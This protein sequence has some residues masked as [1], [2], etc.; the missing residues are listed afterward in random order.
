MGIGLSTS[1]L[2]AEISE[3]PPTCNVPR[4]RVDGNMLMIDLRACYAACQSMEPHP[5]HQGAHGYSTR[6]SCPVSYSLQ[7][8]SP[9]HIWHCIRHRQSVW[10][11]SRA[12]LLVSGAITNL[13]ELGCSFGATQNAVAI[14][15]D[16]AVAS[17]VAGSDSLG[18]IGAIA[19][20]VA[21]AVPNAI[22]SALASAFTCAGSCRLGVPGVNV[23]D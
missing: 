19:S 10:L 22:P 1:A 16:S 23:D 5:H 21:S 9:L 3:A 6:R 7:C 18:V 2:C 14:A 8:N 4:A 11:P 12:D 20:S 15:V 13:C 17:V